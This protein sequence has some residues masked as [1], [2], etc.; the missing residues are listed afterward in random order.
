VHRELSY[1]TRDEG[2]IAGNE[3][4]EVGEAHEA[5]MPAGAGALPGD[6]QIAETEPAAGR[7]GRADLLG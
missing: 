7:Q 3:G 2:S 6:E 4:E 1:G 5:M